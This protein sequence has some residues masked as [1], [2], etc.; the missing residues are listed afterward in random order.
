MILSGS[1]RYNLDLLG[2]RSDEQILAAIEAVG[3]KQTIHGLGGLDSDL[4]A[5]VR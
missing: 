4:R 2:Q 5:K 3:M 1:L